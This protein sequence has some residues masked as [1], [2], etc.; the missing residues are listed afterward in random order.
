M[1]RPE[2]DKPMDAAPLVSVYIPT[3]DRVDLLQRAVDSVL[4]QTYP[5]IEIIISDDGSRDQTQA[6]VA[7]WQKHHPNIVYLRSERSMGACHARNR[8]FRTAKGEYITGLDDDDAFTPDRV[9]T[10]V[11]HYKEGCNFLCALSS[12]Y[13][14][15]KTTPSRYWQPRVGL[16]SILR[17]NSVGTQVFVRLRDLIDKDIFFDE[18]FPA[19]QDYDFVT[20]LILKLGPATRVYRYTYLFYTDH[21][22]DRV[23]NP[24][25]IRAGY[26]LYRKKYRQWMTPAQRC[27]LAV[28]ATMLTGR[29]APPTLT[30]LC[31]KYGNFWDLLR[32][33]RRARR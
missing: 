29:K 19:W 4:G 7:E 15:D 14:G 1:S 6:R 8:A 5:N 21:E 32:I 31:L 24:K 9:A 10:F 22:K 33:L 13:D 16:K 27:S 20:Q 2:S 18:D 17:R 26:Q 3:K 11:S 23:T 25:R 28:T 12:T 30:R